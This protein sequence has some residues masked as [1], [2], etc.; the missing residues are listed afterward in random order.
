[1]TRVYHGRV[2]SGPK[3]GAYW[4]AKYSD[5]I[6]EKIGIKPFPGTLNIAV[7]GPVHYPEKGLFIPSWKERGKYFGAVFLFPAIMLNTKVWVVLPE[8]RNNPDNIIEVISDRRLRTWFGLRDGDEVS[9]EIMD[10]K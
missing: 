7:D 8:I 5:K 2:V 9:I 6:E 10:A 3:E 1:M 4:I